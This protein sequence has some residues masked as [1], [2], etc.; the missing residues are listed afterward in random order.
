MGIDSFSN[1]CGIGVKMDDINKAYD[2][3]VEEYYKKTKILEEP[4]IEIRKY[5]LSL[6]KKPAKILDFSLWTRKRCKNI[7]RKR[8]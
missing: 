3:T 6:I 5:F 2:S 4:E 8:I 1:L 7:F